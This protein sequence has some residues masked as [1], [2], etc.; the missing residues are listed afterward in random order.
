MKGI[1]AYYSSTGNTRLACR[2]IANKLGVP[3]DLVDIAKEK[4]VDLEPYDRD[5]IL[6]WMH[7]VSRQ[8]SGVKCW[9]A[10]SLEKTLREQMPPLQ[11]AD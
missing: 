8:R 9:L 10:A 7:Q 11:A 4:Q 1:I 5:A 6:K 3:F 2:Y